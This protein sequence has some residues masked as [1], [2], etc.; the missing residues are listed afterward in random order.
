MAIFGWHTL[1]STAY[2]DDR[3]DVVLNVEE[4]G[5]E[6]LLPYLDSASSP[7][8]TIGAGFN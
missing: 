2:E 5:T 4:G 7:N 3:Y 8:P 1:S 6:E